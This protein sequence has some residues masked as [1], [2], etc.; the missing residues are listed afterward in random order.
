MYTTADQSNGQTALQAI[1]KRSA[2]GLVE[3]LTADQTHRLNMELDLQS[4]FGLHVHSYAH[5]LRP[6]NHTPL[7]FELIYEGAI[8]QPR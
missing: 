1:E 2:E 7:A 4:L 8:G 5:W 3:W 6:S